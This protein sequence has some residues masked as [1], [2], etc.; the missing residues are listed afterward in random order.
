MKT[1]AAIKMGLNV[2]SKEEYKKKEEE[3]RQNR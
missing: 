1:L 3:P 2:V